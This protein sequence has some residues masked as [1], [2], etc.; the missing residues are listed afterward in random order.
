M[1]HP[2]IVGCSRMNG[3]LVGTGGGQWLVRGSKIAVFELP[4]PASGTRVRV[5]EQLRERATEEVEVDLSDV[6]RTAKRQALD[7]ETLDVPAVTQ[8]A[9]PA[10]ELVAAPTAERTSE[11]EV[12]DI[13]T[14]MPVD[15]T[16]PFEMRVPAKVHARAAQLA[17]KLAR[18]QSRNEPGVPGGRRSLS[19]FAAL[20]AACAVLGVAAGVV[21]YQTAPIPAANAHT[22][23][24]ARPAAKVLSQRTST[25][26]GISVPTV[27]VDSLPRVRR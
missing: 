7:A 26:A 14:A 17:S 2:P 23:K 18:T 24:A 5:P 4:E 19:V 8:A 10:S 6:V 16:E 11:V 21:F 13:I 25:I 1:I 20:F 12:D 27:H 3:A 22:F 9:P 15:P